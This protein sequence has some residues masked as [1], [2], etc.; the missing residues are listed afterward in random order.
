MNISNE[1]FKEKIIEK[2]L[3]DINNIYMIQDYIVLENNEEC[4]NMIS[5]I[6]T[7]NTNNNV[8]NK[9]IKG[10]FSFLLDEK[11]LLISKNDE[12]KNIFKIIYNYL[13]SI[14]KNIEKN[15]DF[16]LINIKSILS[17]INLV[18]IFND[19]ITF[20][21][22]KKKLLKKE[23][24]NINEI[25]LSEYYFTC[26]KNKKGRKSLI[27]WDY[28][29]F[30]YENFSNKIRL[31]NNNNN[32]N[33]YYILNLLKD[34]LNLLDIKDNTF[35]KHSFI[36]KDLELINEI[37]TI[38]SRNY[39]MWTYLRKVYNFTDKEGKK[40]IILFSFLLIRRC[41][42][43]YSAFSFLVNSKK[44]MPL[45]DKEIKILIDELKKVTIIKYDE[46]K[47]YIDDLE[48]FLI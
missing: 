38:Q 25:I 43:D 32:T 7:E 4:E 15:K 41:S 26:T 14:N 27:S 42:F 30:L 19:N 9:M 35:Y 22:F 28:K 5:E 40:I 17:L 1:E 45:N 21:S 12:F 39:H 34:E 31:I 11:Y 48:K 44:N 29:Y 37:N 47:C 18:L 3:Q 10:T 13:L 6:L 33:E 8:S 16:I 24:E 23:I 20:Y 46:H 2:Y 36:L